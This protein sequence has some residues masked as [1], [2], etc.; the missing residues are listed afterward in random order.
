M[1][2][3]GNFKLMDAWSYKNESEE[4]EVSIRLVEAGRKGGNGLE[5]VTTDEEA[6]VFY[7]TF[8][9]DNTTGDGL[10]NVTI[11]VTDQGFLSV[12]DFVASEDEDV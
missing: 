2:I 7:L 12:V 10:F 6:G 8:G 3:I 1:E 9:W 4:S 11:R 5:T